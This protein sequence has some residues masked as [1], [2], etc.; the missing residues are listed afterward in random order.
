MTAKHFASLVAAVLAA[1]LFFGTAAGCDPGTKTEYRDT[2]V[3]SE[4]PDSLV[5][6]SGQFGSSAGDYYRF[7]ETTV[8]YHDNAGAWGGTEGDNGGFNNATIKAVRQFTGTSGVI[9]FKYPGGF[10]YPIYG[11]TPVAALYGAVYYKNLTAS[12]VDAGSTYAASAAD[13]VT[14]SLSAPG[15]TLQGTLKYYLDP[16]NE[17][18]EAGYGTYTKQ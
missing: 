6:G 13:V 10:A 9:V 8:T 5:S 2:I 4:L 7:T 14:R 1:F 16:A 17:P 18:T 15:S 12:S 3:V 11:G